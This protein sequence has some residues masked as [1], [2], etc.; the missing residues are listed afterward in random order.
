M[1]DVNSREG[2]QLLTGRSFRVY[3]ISAVRARASLTHVFE[4]LGS[5][6]FHFSLCLGRVVSGDWGDT[7]AL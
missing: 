2:T 7:E 1:R 4:G 6:T 3:S 5:R